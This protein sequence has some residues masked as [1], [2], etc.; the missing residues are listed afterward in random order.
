MAIDFKTD[1][2]FRDTYTFRNSDAAILRFPFPFI[3]FEGW[4]HS[5]QKLYWLAHNYR[6][7]GAVFEVPRAPGKSE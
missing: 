3:G 4:K 5:M 1:E 7:T 2:T 6:Y